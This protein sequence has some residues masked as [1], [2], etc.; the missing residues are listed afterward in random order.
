MTLLLA[1]LYPIAVQYNREVWPLWVQ[2]H[3]GLAV[4]PAWLRFICS[5]VA[6]FAL[7]VDVAANYT[8]LALL[9]WDWPRKGEHTFST[10][11]LRLRYDTGPRAQV[12]AVVIRCLNFFAPDGKHV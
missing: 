9:T 10:R 11:L 8:E 1:L 5:V 3:L 4:F 2:R 7:L 12:Y 6:F